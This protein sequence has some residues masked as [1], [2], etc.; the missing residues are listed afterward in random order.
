VSKKTDQI[1]PTSLSEIAFILVFLLMVLMGFLLIE[2][3]KAKEI[4]VRELASTRKSQKV[5]EIKK[6]FEEAKEEFSRALEMGG[7]PKPEEVL[8]KLRS[9]VED[10]A[11]RDELRHKVRDLDERLT[12]LTA[13]RARVEAAAGESGRKVERAEVESA[14]ALQEQVRAISPH[15]A[16]NGSNMVAQVKQAI[17]V[18][19]TLRAQLREQLGR[20]VSAGEEKIAVRDVIAAA[21]SYEEF[22]KNKTSAN[23]LKRENSDLR[24]QLAYV[25]RQLNAKGGLDHAP[26]WAD[27]KGKIEYLFTVETR[28]DG[29]LVHKAWLPHREQD[30]RALPGID[31]A[32]SENVMSAPTFAATMQPVLNW[33]KKQEPECRHFVYLTTTVSDADS[34]D[35]ARKVVEGFFYKLESKR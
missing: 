28:P 15:S 35:T 18:A 29:Y 21:K 7:H 30:A 8:T 19:E 13:L 26:C 1:F 17:D 25:S 24:G 5:E 20:T 9:A 33:S 3:S 10:R 16:T 31:H 32:L 4:A 14:L 34:R 2:E 12:A 6:S 11:E 23:V 27:E 22:S